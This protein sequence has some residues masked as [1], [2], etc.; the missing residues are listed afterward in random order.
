MDTRL[1]GCFEQ[2]GMRLFE[3]R[4]AEGGLCKTGYIKTE[5]GSGRKKE[6]RIGRGGLKEERFMPRA[7]AY[8]MLHD[9][10]HAARQ[11]LHHS[12]L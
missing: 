1:D 5:R 4:G 2:T 7:C 3:R 10:V 6:R 9:A 12:R 8:Q 11:H